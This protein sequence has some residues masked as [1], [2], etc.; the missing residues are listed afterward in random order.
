MTSQPL[1]DLEPAA[2]CAFCGA[3]GTDIEFI[4]STTW[5]FRRCKSCGATGPRV[6]AGHGGDSLEA[7]NRRAA[8]STVPEAGKA[9]GRGIAERLHELADSSHSD[10]DKIRLM[11]KAAEAFDR[12]LASVPAPSGAETILDEIAF[13]LESRG[14]VHMANG[15]GIG[16]IVDSLTASEAEATSLRRKLEEQEAAE[17]TASREMQKVVQGLRDRATA[18]ER[19]LEEARKALER[20]ATAAY[21]EPHYLG[22]EGMERGADGLLPPGSPYDRGRYDARKAVEKIARTLS[23]ASDG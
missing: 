10:H 14:Y 23:G 21:G 18:A 22:P 7:W 17:D 11:L 5:C 4:N 15:T 13:A 20:A 9:V 8:R 12:R 19:K 3:D 1:P 16:D 2:P 6:C